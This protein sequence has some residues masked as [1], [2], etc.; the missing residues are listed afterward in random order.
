MQRGYGTVI[1]K[2]DMENRY[3]KQ[4]WKTDTENRYGKQI[5]KTDMALPTQN[6]LPKI[7]V[8]GFQNAL[9]PT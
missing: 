5:R 3:G 4:I 8:D 6:H 2:T 9:A 7:P 1:W